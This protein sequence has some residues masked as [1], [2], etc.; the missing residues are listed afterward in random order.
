MENS[1]TFLIL[2]DIFFGRSFSRPKVQALVNKKESKNEFY[3]TPFVF[4]FQFVKKKTNVFFLIFLIHIKASNPCLQNIK[5]KK[6][7]KTFF[8]I[9]F[10]KFYPKK[11]KFLV[12]KNRIFL[13]KK[14]NFCKKMKFLIVKNRVF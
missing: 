5:K 3:A 11:L 14:Q 6:V 1:S 9:K 12:V 8:F 4:F 7:K 10:Q 2:S 13:T